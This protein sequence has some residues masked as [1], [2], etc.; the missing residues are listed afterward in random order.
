MDVV[1]ENEEM[2]KR[3]QDLLSDGEAAP[4]VKS[5]SYSRNPKHAKDALPGTPT[6]LVERRQSAE[7][8][9][10]ETRQEREGSLVEKEPIQDSKGEDLAAAYR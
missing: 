10:H 2:L 9:G 3:E 1:I 4:I 6:K 8:D 7:N 5:H